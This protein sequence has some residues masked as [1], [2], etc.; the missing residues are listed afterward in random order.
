MEQLLERIVASIPIGN[1]R[2]EMQ[3]TVLNGSVG[4]TYSEDILQISFGDVLTRHY[5]ERHS[6]E[7]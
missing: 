3:R 2:L 6:Y 7:H 4:S 1:A 5:D